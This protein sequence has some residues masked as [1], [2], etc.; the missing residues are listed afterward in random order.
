MPVTHVDV[1]SPRS[2]AAG[3]EVGLFPNIG[4]IAGH[5]QHRVET[6]VAGERSVHS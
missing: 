6:R 2:G 5:E 3:F 1:G 4:T